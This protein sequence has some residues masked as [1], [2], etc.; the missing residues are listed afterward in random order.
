MLDNINA[1]QCDNNAVKSSGEAKEVD[2]KIADLVY[3]LHGIARDIDPEYA[4]SVVKTLNEG[5]STIKRLYEEA[6]Q[7]KE[8]NEKLT[9]NFDQALKGWV[10]A[11][12]KRFEVLDKIMVLQDR[13]SELEEFASTVAVKASGGW[14]CFGLGGKNAYLKDISRLSEAVGYDVLGQKIKQ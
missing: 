13:N 9:A 10:E 4:P 12:Y 2:P 1:N 7:Q 8:T 14:C 11:N 3:S 5:I 6:D